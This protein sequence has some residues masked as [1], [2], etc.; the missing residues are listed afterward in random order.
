MCNLDCENCTYDDCINDGEL[1]NAIHCRNWYENNKDYKREYARAYAAQKRKNKRLGIDT[2]I[3]I[4]LSRQ[5]ARTKENRACIRCNRQIKIVARGLCNKCYVA[6]TRNGNIENYKKR[7]TNNEQKTTVI[8][9]V[10]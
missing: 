3:N 6:E 10:S 9:Q 7:G 4:S 2:P 5:K 1:N 8:Q